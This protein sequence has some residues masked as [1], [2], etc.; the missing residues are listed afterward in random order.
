MHIHVATYVTWYEIWYA[1]VFL[2]HTHVD[3][4]LL[5]FGSS[6]NGFGSYKSDLDI[7]LALPQL[8]EAEQVSKYTQSC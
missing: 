4:N 2:C 6:A 1:A 8:A 3:A 7:C 5:L